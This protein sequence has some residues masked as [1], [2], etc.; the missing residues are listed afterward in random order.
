MARSDALT[1]YLYKEAGRISRHTQADA[2]ELTK[3]CGIGGLKWREVH[4]V[5][6]KPSRY[7]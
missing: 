1:R 2:D 4:Q 3:K 5:K 6:I 7:Q